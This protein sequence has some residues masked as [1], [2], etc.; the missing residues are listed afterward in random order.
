MLHCSQLFRFCFGFLFNTNYTACA[1]LWPMWNVPILESMHFG[2]LKI[3]QRDFETETTS[4]CFPP[5]K[6]IHSFSLVPGLQSQR[7]LL[8]FTWCCLF[9]HQSLETSLGSRIACNYFGHLYLLDRT[10]IVNC[11]YWLQLFCLL[12][13]N[14]GRAVYAVF[15]HMHQERLLVSGSPRKQAVLW[16][17]NRFVGCELKATRSNFFFSPSG[18]WNNMRQCSDI[19]FASKPAVLPEW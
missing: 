5:G 7:Q 2:S 11:S 16:S 9:L 8:Y 18:E 4:T 15:V 1:G 10:P 13:L 6:L 12:F 14:S 19:S 3:W 17:A